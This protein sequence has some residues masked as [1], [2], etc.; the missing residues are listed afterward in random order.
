MLRTSRTV[1][2]MRGPRSTRS[3][4]KTALRPS[5][6]A[7]HWSTAD[8]GRR[9]DGGRDRVTQLPQQSF[10]FVAAAVDVADDVERAVLVA[11][12]VLQRH[13]LD[14]GGF[15]LL[16]GLQHEDW[17]KPSL[18]RPRSDRRSCDCCWRTTWGPKS[19]SS[20]SRLRS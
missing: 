9:L 18:A 15:D 1:S 6:C 3:P 2:R 14:R 12:V 16:G 5:G 4:T 10:Q 13:P 11:F 20:R 17:R 8:A 19:R 7:I